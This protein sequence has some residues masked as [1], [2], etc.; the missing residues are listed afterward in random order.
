MARPSATRTP[1]SS[2]TRRLSRKVAALVASEPGEV[3]T[4]DTSRS[5]N[6]KS[7][8]NGA[9]NGTPASAFKTP[10]TSAKKSGHIKFDDDSAGGGEEDGVNG[11][12]D[13]PR[14][15]YVTA[16]EDFSDSSGH[17]NAESDDDDEAP[18]D[19]S[20]QGG[21][22]AAIVQAQERKREVEILRDEQ[23][24]KRK[25]NDARLRA[26]KEA[27]KAK[28]AENDAGQSGKRDQLP[29]FLPSSIL[30]EVTTTPDVG[31]INHDDDDASKKSKRKKTIFSEPDARD[32]P[33]GDVT[34]RVLKT[35]KLKTMPPPAKTKLLK[36]REKWLNRK[37][38]RDGKAGHKIVI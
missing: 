28:S 30:K 38:I 15:G 36:S 10:L 14:T 1:Q 18:E 19:V 21:R 22:Q 16:E 34:L 9:T 3:S 27:K 2:S 8:V 11:V 31:S 17:G 7:V 6:G 29:L 25:A 5:A 33:K 12:P 35:Q 4:P 13:T 24:A 37:S 20:F 32:I 26:Q 23:R